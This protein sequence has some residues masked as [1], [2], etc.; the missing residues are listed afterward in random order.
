M[1]DEE[2]QKMLEIYMEAIES[3]KVST[4]IAL[5]DELEKEKTVWEI[6]ALIPFSIS[7]V[8]LVCAVYQIVIGNLQVAYIAIIVFSM[9]SW[10]LLAVGLRSDSHK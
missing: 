10:L 9:C 6:T 4:L 2:L 1:L 5:C 8:M 3:V 7:V